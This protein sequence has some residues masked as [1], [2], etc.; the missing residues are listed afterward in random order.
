MENTFLFLG[1]LIF[2]PVAL[3]IARFLG[4]YSIVGECESQVFTLFGKVIGTLEEPGLQFPI[5]AFGLKAILV[6]FFGKKYSVGTQL[7]QHY[8]RSQMVNSE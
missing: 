1:G 2:I 8:L 7:R 5:G 6:P 3:G 4:L